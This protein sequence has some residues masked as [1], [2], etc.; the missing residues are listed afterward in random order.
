M[1]ADVIAQKERR[2]FR[3]VAVKRIGRKHVAGAFHHGEAVV[4]HIGRQGVFGPFDRVVDVDQRHVFIGAGFEGQ[5]EGVVAEVVR[6]RGVV[7]HI[8]GAVD[9]R[10]QRGGDG[11]GDHLGARARIGGHDHDGRRRNLRIFR[12]RQPVDRDDARQHEEERDHQREPGTPDE[13]C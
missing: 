11:V 6:L 12:D 10:L 8:L 2:M 1:D 5:R 7:D 9:L 3:I 4:D 13:N